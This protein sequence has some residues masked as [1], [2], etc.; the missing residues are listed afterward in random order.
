MDTAEGSSGG[1]T[2]DTDATESD[3]SVPKKGD[4]GAFDPRDT[5]HP[6]G[7]AQAEENAENESP[8]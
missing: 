3:R 6:T 5:A 8:S 4:P 2:P 1:P 7:Q